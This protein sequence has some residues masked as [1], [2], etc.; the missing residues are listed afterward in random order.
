MNISTCTAPHGAHALRQ[1]QY[2]AW[3]V[4]SGKKCSSEAQ[5]PPTAMRAPIH[6]R[7]SHQE[8]GMSAESGSQTKKFGLP[9]AK[10][11]VSSPHCSPS[12]TATCGL[13]GVAT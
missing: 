8:P 12:P 5:R 1:A 6:T 2:T 9:G 7:V 11:C 3:R 4:G 13:V 10:H